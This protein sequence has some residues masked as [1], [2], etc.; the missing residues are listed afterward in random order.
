MEELKAVISVREAVSL[1]G[2]SRRHIW[3][4]CD[5][6]AF[7]ARQAETVWLINRASFLEFLKQLNNS[8]EVLA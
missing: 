5:I 2:Y 6:G 3:Y 1:S 8:M 4:W 7:E